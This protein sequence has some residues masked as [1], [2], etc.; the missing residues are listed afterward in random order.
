M[1]CLS[2]NIKNEQKQQK[3]NES[4]FQAKLSINQ[5]GD[6]YEQEADAVAEK[7]MRMP[8]PSINNNSFFKPGITSIQ[9][10]CAGCEEENKIQPKENNTIEAGVSEASTRLIQ[11]QSPAPNNNTNIQA[12]CQTPASPVFESTGGDMFVIS[13]VTKPCYACPN[14]LPNACPKLAD[15]IIP[16]VATGPVQFSWQVKFLTLGE[17][18]I[19]KKAY[20]IQK[21][22]KVFNFSVPPP[23]TYSLSTLYWEAFELK[24]RQTDIDYWQFEIPDNTAGTWEMN[25]SL[26][27]ADQLPQGMIANAAPEAHGLPSSTS[28]PKG[29]GRIRG[30]RRITGKFD[31]TGAVKN[32]SFQ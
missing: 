18:N 8:C 15:K 32:H 19:E 10:K 27:L 17:G 11:R 12:F 6:M 23:A 14:S 9:R 21:I 25:A 4:F 24:N 30:T 31:F 22:N 1:N 5:P 29:L 13:D 20:V 7:I 26:Y 16:P 28:E 3:A 2:H